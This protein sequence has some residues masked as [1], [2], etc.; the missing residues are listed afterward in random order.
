M[1]LSSL[2]SSGQSPNTDT[3]RLASVLS[4][5]NGGAKNDTA[6]MINALSQI[7]NPNGGG[8]SSSSPINANI[9]NL[10]S[11]ANKNSRPRNPSG[12]KPIKDIVPNDI[13]GILVKSLT[14]S[15]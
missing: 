6:S 4:A 12:L 11:L 5:M 2:L 1:D 9:L 7:H 15:L 10:L 3:G 14:E 8:D 13:L